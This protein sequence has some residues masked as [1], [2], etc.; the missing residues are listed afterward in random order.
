MDDVQGVDATLPQFEIEPV[1]SERIRLREIERT[2]TG[3]VSRGVKPFGSRRGRE[4]N[5]RRLLADVDQMKASTF[6]IPGRDDPL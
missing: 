4:E 3:W 1:R 5:R 6:A 2:G